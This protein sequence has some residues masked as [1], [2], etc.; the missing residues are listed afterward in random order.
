MPAYDLGAIVGRTLEVRNAAGVLVDSTVTAAVTVPAGTSAPVT[1]NHTGTGL[2]GV[3]YLTAAAG[4]HVLAWHSTGTVALDRYERFLVIDRALDLAG[5]E[6]L[7]QR[8]QQTIPTAS[9]GSA[10]EALDFA[11]AL[12]RGYCGKQIT[13]T[14]THA[15]VARGVIIDSA[16]RLFTNPVMR[17]AY[18]GPEGLTYTPAAADAML[19]SWERE[20]LSALRTPG[21]A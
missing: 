3:D 14:E 9:R 15:G 13:G 11:H 1:V 16:A 19:T 7:E 6:D 5:V 20:A 10:Q 2:F 18:T 8:L 4:W 21:F 12:V 17:S